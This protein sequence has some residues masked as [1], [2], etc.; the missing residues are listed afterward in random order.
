M[1]TVTERGRILPQKRAQSAQCRW[2]QRQSASRYA[3][4]RAGMPALRKGGTTLC[5]MSQR[6]GV[7][8]SAV[9]SNFSDQIQEDLVCFA[10]LF[11]AKSY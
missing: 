4:R 2:I 8:I 1:D 10:G 11:K 7:I 6:L 5:Q 9:V 3:L